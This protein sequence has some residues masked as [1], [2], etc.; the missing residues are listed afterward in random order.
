MRRASRTAG[1]VQFEP[2]Q[3][4]KRGSVRGT[5]ATAADG[6]QKSLT[7][8]LSQLSAKGRQ[9]VGAD[10][11]Q[12]DGVRRRDG[13]PLQPGHEPP[14]E[15]TPGRENGSQAGRRSAQDRLAQMRRED[16]DR[17]G[18][19]RAVRFMAGLLGFRGDIRQRSARRRAGRLVEHGVK[20]DRC[21]LGGAPHAARSMMACARSARHRQCTGNQRQQ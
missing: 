9:A 10:S 1:L 13:V 19:V 16:H 12:K 20:R 2:D 6:R 18:A 7:R 11:H 21:G 4:S 5:S 8:R 14:A 3:V 17:Q 15:S